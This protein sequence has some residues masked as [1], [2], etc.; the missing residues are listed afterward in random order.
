MQWIELTT[1][2][3][4]LRQ[5]LEMRAGRLPLPRT[6]T[7][8]VVVLGCVLL[9]M[10]TFTASAGPI[11]ID[12]GTVKV[13]CEGTPCIVTVTVKTNYADSLGTYANSS[14]DTSID[15]GIVLAPSTQAPDS[16][17]YFHEFTHV[18]AA[19]M[20]LIPTKQHPVRLTNLPSNTTY[21]YAPIAVADAQYKTRVESTFKIGVLIDVSAA[22]WHGNPVSE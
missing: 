8:L 5:W 2:W 13:L 7:I 21:H 1:L 22:G 12:P 6:H 10:H 3:Q 16:T 15:A 4:S 20:Q 9:T 17:I 18:D 14:F 19:T 11:T